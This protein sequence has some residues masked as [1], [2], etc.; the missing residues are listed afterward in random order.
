M[1][2]KKLAQDTSGYLLVCDGV[3]VYSVRRAQTFSD[4]QREVDDFFGGDGIGLDS[5]SLARALGYLRSSESLTV[6]AKV[7]GA[8]RAIEAGL[9]DDSQVELMTLPEAI[10]GRAGS[11]IRGRYREAL[12]SD[13]ES[14]DDDKFNVSRI[15]AAL[16]TLGPGPL[17]PTEVDLFLKWI[18]TEAS[19]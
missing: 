1:G 5:K 2:R 17:G 8:C 18:N 13:I 11:T 19:G 15:V 9:D 4:L 14:I 7:R 16:E 6:R 10:S 12:L 3:G